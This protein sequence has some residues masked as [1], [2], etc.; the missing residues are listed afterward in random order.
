[1]SSGSFTWRHTSYI[2]LCLLWLDV[3]DRNC[4]SLDFLLYVCAP[5]QYFLGA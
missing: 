1:M 5:E 3:V 4:V 2:S